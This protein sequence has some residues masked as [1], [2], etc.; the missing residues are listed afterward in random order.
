MRII[1]NN[2]IEKFDD[3]LLKLSESLNFLY[4]GR[5][6][7]EEPI[8]LI[9]CNEEIFAIFKIWFNELKKVGIIRFPQKIF[10]HKVFTF[11][12][13]MF[14]RFNI[15]ILYQILNFSFK[16]QIFLLF[17]TL[18]TVIGSKIDASTI[19]IS[20]TDD[21][22][23]Y[24]LTD[25][26]VY[27]TRYSLDDSTK[28]SQEISKFYMKLINKKITDINK[29][30]EYGT[31]D[32]I[33][34]VMD[35]IEEVE[36][37]FHALEKDYLKLENEKDKKYE[38]IN[39][40]REEKKKINDKI[41]KLEEYIDSSDSSDSLDSLDS[42]DDSLDSSDDSEND[43]KINLQASR[44]KREIKNEIYELKDKRYSIKSKISD[45]KNE[46]NELEEEM[47]YID[48]NEDD[49]IYKKEDL[50][51]DIKALK[52][53][54]TVH[55]YEYS[56]F[57]VKIALDKKG[58]FIK[59]FNEDYYDFCYSDKQPKQIEKYDK[60]EI[61]V[62]GHYRK[63]LIPI[64]HYREEGIKSV[65]IPNHIT[66]IEKCAFY[67]SRVKSLVIPDSIK[68]IN[69]SAFEACS[70]LTSIKLPNSLTV[71]K[72]MLFENCPK[73][74]TIEIPDSVKVIGYKAFKGCSNLKQI[75]NLKN[76]IIIQELA[77]ADCTNL[78]NITI[79]KLF[80]SSMV[81]NNSFKNCPNLTIETL[82]I[83]IPF[84]QNKFP[85]IKFKAIDENLYTD[86]HVV[87]AN[88]FKNDLTLHSIK[89]NDCITKIENGAFYNC[90]NLHKVII[91][92]NGVRV[93]KKCFH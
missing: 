12:E 2:H 70:Y 34:E 60:N 3:K 26:D 17:E 13:N 80:S 69:E 65:L 86:C 23:N 85:N 87:K 81:F 51:S 29:K 62:V 67:K 48:K 89:L 72:P 39:A 37:E 84:L 79:P 33:D 22:N 35:K 38:K 41:E 7:D 78:K 31:E 45:Y 68:M 10:K 63:E 15:K 8:P 6:D 42:S 66:E 75:S 91:P 19:S 9:D 32:Q 50:Y 53:K 16:N 40:L 61:D 73:L 5:E 1:F 64:Y 47:S 76:I 83:Q 25:N 59:H 27:T 46:I 20:S 57:N 28:K 30:I 55:S 90:P 56:P 24:T 74:E 43:D 58:F 92:N 36:E 4:E 88:T 49:L 93:E 77:F 52:E 44:N 54:N 11:K 18:S 82:G 14:E 21:E 71:I